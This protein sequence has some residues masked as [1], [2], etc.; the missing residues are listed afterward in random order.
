MLFLVF[1]SP[2]SSFSHFIIHLRTLCSKSLFDPKVRKGAKKCQKGENGLQKTKKSIVYRGVGAMGAKWTLRRPGKFH[3]CEIPHFCAQN[4]FWA[5]FTVLGA[6][7]AKN[8]SWAISGSKN[9][10]RCLCF[11]LFGARGEKYAFLLKSCCSE[12]KKQYKVIP[13]AT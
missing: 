1:W 6:K 2:F 12:K 10:P 4:A 7:R 9:V 8:R 3:F 11:P 13:C 5:L